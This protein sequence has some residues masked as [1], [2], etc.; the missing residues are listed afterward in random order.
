MQRHWRFHIHS[1]LQTKL[2][3]MK[4]AQ[5]QTMSLRETLNRLVYYA[6]CVYTQGGLPLLIR[7]HTRCQYC[8]RWI[9]ARPRYHVSRIIGKYSQWKISTF[10][11]RCFDRK[12]EGLFSFYSRLVLVHSFL[13]QRSINR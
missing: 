3:F 13:L 7:E 9:T 6:F 11:K 1:F 5:D 10:C 12:L 4:E 8:R 2:V